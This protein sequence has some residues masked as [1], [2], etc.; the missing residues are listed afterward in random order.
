MFREADEVAVRA[1]T[2]LQLFAF[3]GESL[4]GVVELGG[5][6][7]PVGLA[8]TPVRGE[9][10]GLLEPAAKL[11][12]KRWDGR[13]QA[14]LVEGFEP[15]LGALLEAGDPFGE[16]RFTAAEFVAETADGVELFDQLFFGEIG[17][18]VF[19][20]GVGSGAFQL[21]PLFGGEG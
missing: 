13:R 17:G 9:L 14:F 4:F 20:F 11:V 3:K 6:F 15:C 5:P 1:A 12:W 7:C 18:G 10:G 19:C 2:G 16:T 8:F 21:G